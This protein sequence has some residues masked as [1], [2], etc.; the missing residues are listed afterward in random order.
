MA[1]RSPETSYRSPETT[2]RSPEAS[3]RSP[4]GSQRDLLSGGIED[5]LELQKSREVAEPRPGIPD[6]RPA[7][8]QKRPDPSRR[9]SPGGARTAGTGTRG[10]GITFGGVPIGD[11]V[12]SSRAPAVGGLTGTVNQYL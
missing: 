11:L 1:S 12:H 2:Y 7:T 9:P 6:Q 4:E 10:N 8:H 3:Y 5:A